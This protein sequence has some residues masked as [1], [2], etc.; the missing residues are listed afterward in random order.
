[1]SKSEAATALMLEHRLNCAQSVLSV[2]SQ[3]AGLDAVTA[4]RV[5]APFGG[6]MAR[7]GNTCGAVTG[8]YMAL[9]LAQKLSLDNPRE[10]LD[11]TYQL[12]RK[13]NEEFKA[14]HGTLVCRELIGC[15]LSTPEGMAEAREKKVFASIC[16]NLVG[17]AAR[18]VESL[19]NPG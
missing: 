19:L 17:D 12:A 9:G 11:K 13:L 8:A 1:M 18:I 10:G 16:P 2:F 3:E 4:L 6:G 5:A 7:S 14:L 15:D